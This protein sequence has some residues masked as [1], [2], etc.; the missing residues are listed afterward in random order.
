MRRTFLLLTVFAFLLGWFGLPLSEAAPPPGRGDI[1]GLVLADGVAA[2]GS[3]VQLF[4]GSGID[5]VAET[6]TNSSGNFRFRK[7]AAGDYT[8]TASRFGGG[9]ACSGNAPVTV[10]SGQ[11]VNVTVSMTCQ[12]F[13]PF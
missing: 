8:V 11:T 13:P 5:Y 10:V 12:I 2:P 9:A 1:T 3:T 6:V 4:N 7:I